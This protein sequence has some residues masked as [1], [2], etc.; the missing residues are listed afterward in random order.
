MGAEH[1]AA[2]A[3]AMFACANRTAGA[4][5]NPGSGSG[6]QDISFAASLAKCGWVDRDGVD[7]LMK[8]ELG[9][10]SVARSEVAALQPTP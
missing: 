2:G 9:A 7:R 10:A 6:A 3:M 1:R 5:G 4:I 8:W